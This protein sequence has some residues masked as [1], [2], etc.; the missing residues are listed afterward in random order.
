MPDT[1][2]LILPAFTVPAV[3]EIVHSF[4]TTSVSKRTNDNLSISG[5][6]LPTSVA[7]G[8]FVREFMTPPDGTADALM[9]ARDVLFSN[10]RLGP[11][12]FDNR[13]MFLTVGADVSGTDYIWTLVDG[14][15]VSVTLENH[16]RN[17]EVSY[18]GRVPTIFIPGQDGTR[19]ALRED[20]IGTTPTFFDAS[21]SRDDITVTVTLSRPDFDPLDFSFIPDTATATFD[22]GFNNNLA[23][24]TASAVGPYTNIEVYTS[25]GR[26]RVQGLIRLRMD[27]PLPLNA[28]VFSFTYNLTQGRTTTRETR[29]VITG[30][31]RSTGYF[32]R[33]NNIWQAT[34]GIH[35][36]IRGG[37]T[38]PTIRI[39]FIN[40][41]N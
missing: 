4:R 8:D 9:Q 5:P 2:N 12:I 33:S 31:L 32:S 19:W 18:S 37:D 29:S 34:R 13:G 25:G 24:M 35:D 26:S 30:I 28:A 17:M 1:L 11:R 23:T 10:I 38:M 6:A 14:T 36:G 39:S 3:P 16:T 15:I 27:Q 20:V 41:Y 22:A 21:R 40:A 7:D